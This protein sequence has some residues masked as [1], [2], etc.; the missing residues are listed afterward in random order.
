MLLK[1]VQPIRLLYSNQ[2]KILSV[3]KIQ[4]KNG[5]HLISLSTEKTVVNLKTNVSICMQCILGHSY[6]LFDHGGQNTMG[7]GSKIP[8][9]GVR[10]TMDRGVNITWIGGLIYHG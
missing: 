7:R 10:Y 8:W 6:I 1:A 4:L 2:I 9:K 3:I 5:E